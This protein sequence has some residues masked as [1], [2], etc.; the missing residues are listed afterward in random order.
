MTSPTFIFQV[1][2]ALGA[3]LSD[4]GKLEK[5]LKGFIE[6][7]LRAAEKELEIVK[8]GVRR[9]NLEDIL[10]A[11]EIGAELTERARPSTLLLAGGADALHTDVL[12]FLDFV[13]PQSL[14]LQDVILTL[15]GFLLEPTRLPGEACLAPAPLLRDLLD[16]GLGK[17]KTGLGATLS[18]VGGSVKDLLLPGFTA[19]GDLGSFVQATL[20]DPIT[21]ALNLVL[22]QR[23]K[24][25]CVVEGS[26]SVGADV[27]DSSTERLTDSLE[28]L[29]I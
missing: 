18:E 15:S 24:I 1:G 3:A 8:E 21:A 2:P 6:D 25:D 27:I 28:V 20:D 7:L 26:L 11:A 12:E 23:D 16:I 13:E 29:L 22:G 10:A 19:L 14:S 5:P 17:L 9:D 4:P